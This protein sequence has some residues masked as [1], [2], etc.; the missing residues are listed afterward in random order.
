[1]GEKDLQS[2]ISCAGKVYQ[3]GGGFIP[4][5]DVAILCL[6]AATHNGPSVVGGSTGAAGLSLKAA[7]I[8][9]AQAAERLFLHLPHLVP[10]S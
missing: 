5:R 3:A 6:G 7:P 2:K 9:I 4:F 1:M 10:P 8:L